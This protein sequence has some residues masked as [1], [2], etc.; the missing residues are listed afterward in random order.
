MQCAAQICITPKLE[1]IARGGQG[2]IMLGKAFFAY[3]E[4]I[5]QFIFSHECAHARGIMDEEAADCFAICE[6]K[7]SGWL[8]MG[9]LQEVCSQFFFNPGDRTH[10]P[11]PARCLAMASCYH[12]C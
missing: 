6:G 3:P 4:I 8:D 12:R 11:G 5:Q 2:H 9:V 1:G 10:S 7:H